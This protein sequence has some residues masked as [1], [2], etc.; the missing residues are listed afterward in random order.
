MRTQGHALQHWSSSPRLHPGWQATHSVLCEP[1]GTILHRLHCLSNFH[2]EILAAGQH[3]HLPAEGS[4][5]RVH[6]KQDCLHRQHSLLWSEAGAATVLTPQSCRGQRERH[7]AKLPIR[8]RGT[9]ANLQ[10]LD[11]AAPGAGKTAADS[12]GLAAKKYLAVHLCFYAGFHQTPAH[13]HPRR[14][15]LSFAAPAFPAHHPCSQ[16]SAVHSRHS[17]PAAAPDTGACG[18]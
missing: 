8:S 18:A 17:A 3:D 10:T 11:C 6:T 16:R 2:R 9:R 13:P 5:T 14:H 4:A 1:S 15:W 7:R 12:H